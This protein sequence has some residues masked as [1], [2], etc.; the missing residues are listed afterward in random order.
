MLA[1]DSDDAS[2]AFDF[3]VD[4]LCSHVVER[5]GALLHIENYNCTFLHEQ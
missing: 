3:S 1:L 2:E 5:K 4:Q